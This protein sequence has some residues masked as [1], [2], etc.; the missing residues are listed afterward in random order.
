M[1]VAVL[2]AVL[3]VGAEV[4]MALAVEAVS[5]AV[6]RAAEMDTI[7]A[8]PVVCAVVATAPPQPVSR[9][10]PRMAMRDMSERTRTDPFTSR[11]HKSTAHAVTSVGSGR[12]S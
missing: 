2:D 10:T 11:E 5:S 7:V 1:V 8:D 12:G 4:V 6:V 9:K 3:L